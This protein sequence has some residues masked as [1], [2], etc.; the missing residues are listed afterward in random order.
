MPTGSLKYR[1]LAVCHDSE[2]DSKLADAIKQSPG[3]CKYFKSVWLVATTETPKALFDRLE[4]TFPKSE[5]VFIIEVGA[6]AA[7]SYGLMPKEAWKWIEEVRKATTQ[8]A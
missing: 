2:T 1:I 3:W 7:A 4:E 6:S 5:S 8:S